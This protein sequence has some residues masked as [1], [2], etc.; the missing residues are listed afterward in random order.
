[1]ARRDI[2]EMDQIKRRWKERLFQPDFRDLSYA[3]QGKELG[4][5]GMTIGNW[6]REIHPARWQEILDMT[7]KESAGPTL[8]IDD[9]LR[10]QALGG[11]VAAIKL[12]YEIH[13]WSPKQNL[14]ISRRDPE[15]DEKG[16]MDL[17]RDVIKSIPVEK[18][19]EFLGLPPPE[20]PAEIEFHTN[21][22]VELVDKPVE[23]D[24]G[25]Q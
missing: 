5:S 3:D 9:A 7:R 13:G 10:R 2:A 20:E 24:K 23:K 1:M 25:E 14:E 8:E 15:L 21:G 11:D 17:V 12:W 19:L 22:A 16:T 18:R 6:R 4:V